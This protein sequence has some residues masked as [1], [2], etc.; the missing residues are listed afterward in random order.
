[1]FLHYKG[2]VTVALV[3]GLSNHS[4]SGSLDRLSVDS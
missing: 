2:R 1:M 4:T 3:P